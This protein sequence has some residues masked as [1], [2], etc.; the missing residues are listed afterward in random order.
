MSSQESGDERQVAFGKPVYDADGNE[1]G[2][3][4]GLDEHGFYVTTADDVTAMSVDHE[5]EARSGHKELH[6]RCWSCGE[7]GKLDEMPEICPSCGA[8]EEDLY[9]WQQD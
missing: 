1:L 2:R 8:P 9:Y 5:A 4:R 6:W 3:V 7:I